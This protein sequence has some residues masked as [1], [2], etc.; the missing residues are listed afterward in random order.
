MTKGKPRNGT[1][2]PGGR[3]TKYDP[4]FCE[5]VNEYLEQEQDEWDEFHKVRGLKSDGFERTLTVHLPSREGFADFIG[6]SHDALSDWEV[7]FPMFGV[8]LRKIDREQK[9][10]LVENGLS[11]NYNPLIAKLVLAANHGMRDATDV[12]SGGKPIKGIGLQFE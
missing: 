8:A 12:T 1:K 4:K 3:P 11:G 6:F 2:N 7:K 9:R 5:K 10:R